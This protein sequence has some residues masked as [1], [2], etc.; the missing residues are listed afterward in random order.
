M[1]EA[2][3]YNKG[4]I[5]GALNM[6]FR[7][8]PLALHLPPQDF[9]KDF[10]FEKP[11]KDLELVL[12]CASGFRAGKAKTEA[13]EAGFKNVSL[14]PGSMNDWTSKGGKTI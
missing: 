2:E 13:L 1:R 3:E 8:H 5:P 10:G 6:P 12:L 11:Q 9:Q 14:Y 4:H 7:S